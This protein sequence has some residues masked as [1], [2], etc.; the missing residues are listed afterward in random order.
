MFGFFTMT[1]NNAFAQMPVLAKA[2]AANPELEAMRPL[3]RSVIARV[4]RVPPSHADVEDCT[5]ECM[6]RG[7]SA[8]LAIDTHERKRAVMV[9]MARNVATDRW[10]QIVRRKENLGADE[11]A[12]CADDSGT[13]GALT[14]DGVFSRGEE[15]QIARL[16][17]QKVLLAMARLPEGQQRA[18][19][20]HLLGEHDYASIAELLNVPIGTVATW[21]ARGRARLVDDLTKPRK[22]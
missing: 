11:S 16:D 22:E 8:L 3:L 7:L 2:G 6:T 21:I 13:H 14:D 9:G 5:Q 12:P 10:R 15:K 18:L 19:Q 4:L 20:L 17:A 1:M